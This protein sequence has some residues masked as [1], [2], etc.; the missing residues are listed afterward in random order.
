MP[1]PGKPR[2]LVLNQ[3]YWPGV[4]ATAQLLTELCE[5]LALD[6]AVKVVTGVL[7]GLEDEPRRASHNGVDIVRV[8]STSFE[9]SKI[10]ARA[11]NYASYL[12]N[13]LLRSVRGP[14]PDVVLCM[15]DPPIVANIALL[16]ARRYRAP[17]VVISQDVFPEIAVQLKRLENPAL[18]SLLRGLVRFYLRRADR[19]VAIGET[20]R[21]RLEEKGAPADRIRVIPNWVDTTRLGPLERANP[22]AQNAQLDTKFVVM[23]SGN[24]GHAQDLDSLVRA[25]TFLRDLDD[26]RIMIIGTGAR[27]A[28]LVG[29]AELL[30]VEQVQFLYYQSRT[31]LSQSL[32]AADVHVVGLAPGLAGYVVPSRLYGILAVARPVI[33]AADAESETAQVVER[34]GCGIVVPPGR[35][36]LLARAIRDAHDGRYDLEAMGERGRAWVVQE[37]DRSVAVGRY[38][39]LLLGLAHS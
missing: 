9:R 5:A 29:L 25:A 38:R 36:E 37:G 26:L 35:P 34:V 13:A 20:M 31:V 32:S 27:H 3:Y 2:L 39:D 6:M 33:V 12:T 4:E 19:I 28:E 24:V 22:W 7:H 15:T 23:H 17:L 1:R 21:K 14:R 8:P 30:D 10:F 16:V 11:S 18:M